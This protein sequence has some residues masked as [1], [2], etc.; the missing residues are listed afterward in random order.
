MTWNAC[1]P[2][3]VPDD[4]YNEFGCAI[5]LL[6]EVSKTHFAN[7]ILGR[8]QAVANLGSSNTHRCC[9]IVLDRY[10]LDL[11]ERRV[12]AAN[13]WVQVTLRDRINQEVATLVSSHMPNRGYA[14]DVFATHTSSLQR[15]PTLT[16]HRK[17]LVFQKILLYERP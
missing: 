7:R 5:Y 14:L 9:A 13:D 11:Q 8:W 6:Q 15:P 4:L 17:E 12:G 10:K 3:V 1:G 2:E 16:S